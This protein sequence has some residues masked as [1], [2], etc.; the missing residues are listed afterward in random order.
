MGGQVRGCPSIEKAVE[1]PRGNQAG[2]HD[3]EDRKGN[4]GENDL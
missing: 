4:V 1:L 3:A 2:N